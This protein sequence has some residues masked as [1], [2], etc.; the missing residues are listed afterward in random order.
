MSHPP[1]MKRVDMVAPHRL[2]EEIRARI[3]RIDLFD[4][5]QTTPEVNKN[6]GMMIDLMEQSGREIIPSPL[7]WPRYKITFSNGVERWSICRYSKTGR[8]KLLPQRDLT[9]EVIYLLWPIAPITEFNLMKRAKKQE[10][11]TTKRKS[12]ETQRG[13][14]R[15]I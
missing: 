1:R 13:G 2:R 9:D 10:H 14:K 15:K 8:K 6:L 11:Q 7:N 5:V 4:D 3:T 12:K